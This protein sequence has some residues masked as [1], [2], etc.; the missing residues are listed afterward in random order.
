M[1]KVWLIT[2]TS[3]WLWFVGKLSDDLDR[4][5]CLVPAILF[6]LLRDISVRTKMR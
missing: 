6:L 3:I 1:V 2:C 4:V 5:I